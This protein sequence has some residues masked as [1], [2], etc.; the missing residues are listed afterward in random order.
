MEKEYAAALIE[1]LVKVEA[2]EVVEEAAVQLTD[3]QMAALDKEL[4]AINHNPDYLVRWHD[5]RRKY[6]KG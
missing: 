3:K 2:V 6:Q 4:E 5:V 1:D